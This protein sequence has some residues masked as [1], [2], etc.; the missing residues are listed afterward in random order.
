MLSYNEFSDVFLP[1]GTYSYSIQTVKNYH[2]V[3]YSSSFTIDGNGLV[4]KVTF[5]S[6]NYTVTFFDNGLPVGTTWYLNITGGGQAMNPI[7]HP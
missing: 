6:T 7:L 2:P 5:V 3:V 4:I 1:N